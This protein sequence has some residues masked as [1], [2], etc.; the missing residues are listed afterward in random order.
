MVNPFSEI[1]CSIIGEEKINKIKDL[2]ESKFPNSNIENLC[3]SD[4][5]AMKISVDKK[6]IEI[7]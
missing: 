4:T 6:S 3:E 5:D 2:S 7:S 1:Y